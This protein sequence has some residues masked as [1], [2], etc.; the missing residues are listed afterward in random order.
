MRPGKARQARFSTATYTFSAQIAASA[1]AGNQEC[2]R[3]ELLLDG[4]TV[5]S[6][7]FG[8]CSSGQTVRSTLVGAALVTTPGSHVL[9]VRVSRPFITNGTTLEQY[10]DNI[11]VVQKL[12]KV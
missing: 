3:F 7:L 1:S 5:A 9:S 4:S 2:G 8:E 12:T 6:H 10:V 11:R